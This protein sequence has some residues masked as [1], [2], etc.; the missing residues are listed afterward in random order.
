MFGHKIQI[1]STLDFYRQFNHSIIVIF[2]IQF[3]S[4]LPEGWKFLVLVYKKWLI[5]REIQSFSTEGKVNR[6]GYSFQLIN[7]KCSVLLL[8]LCLLELLSHFRL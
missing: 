5:F 6:K 8:F 3:Q 2:C 1:P 7:F 4:F